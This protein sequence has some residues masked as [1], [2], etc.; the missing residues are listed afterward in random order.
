MV[1]HG[2][3]WIGGGPWGW[4]AVLGTDWSRGT[5]FGKCACDE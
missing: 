4:P 2:A 5:G 3:C 1:L